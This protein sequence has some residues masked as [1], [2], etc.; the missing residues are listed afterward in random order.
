MFFVV[1][2]IRQ[3][4]LTTVDVMKCV[5]EH[6]DTPFVSFFDGDTVIFCEFIKGMFF[7]VVDF[8]D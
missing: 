2:Y 4:I 6:N 3:R 8:S 1:C 7:V 5:E